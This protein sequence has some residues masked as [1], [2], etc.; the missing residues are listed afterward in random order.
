MKDHQMFV[1][2]D[3]FRITSGEK[4]SIIFL[5]TVKASVAFLDAHSSLRQ[6]LEKMRSR[7]YTAMPVIAEDG[8]YIGT[9]SEG[10]FLRHMLETG[11]YT[12]KSQ[13]NYPITGII[14]EGWNPAVRIDA[15][16]DE[17]YLRITDQNFVPVIDDRGKFVGIITR[18]NILKYY[19]EMIERFKSM[20]QTAS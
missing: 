15:T 3:R 7:G 17:L 1:D 20:S 8:T 19:Y 13:E 9:V 5:L 6:G 2:I 4:K 18:K 12:M 16:M 10:D 14:R 11:A